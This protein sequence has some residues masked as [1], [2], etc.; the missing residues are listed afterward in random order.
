MAPHTSVLIHVVVVS[1]GVVVRL[2]LSISPSLV[3]T[4]AMR[5]LSKAPGR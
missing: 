5:A 2:P 3:S 1:I 4:I